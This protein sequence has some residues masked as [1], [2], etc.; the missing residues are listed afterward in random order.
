MGEEEER[1]M[2]KRIVVAVDE[3]KESMTALSWCLS[4]LIA[5]DNPDN[6]VLVL[7][8]VKPP[9]PVYSYFDAAGEFFSSQACRWLSYGKTETRP[10]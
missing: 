5:R 6:I 1:K 7:L 3:S 9:P 8:Y 2:G 10:T 4:N